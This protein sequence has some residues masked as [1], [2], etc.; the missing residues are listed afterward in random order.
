MFILIFGKMNSSLFLEKYV[1]LGG[2]LV[3]INTHIAHHSLAKKL[4]TLF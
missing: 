1:F 3:I 4:I 2:W